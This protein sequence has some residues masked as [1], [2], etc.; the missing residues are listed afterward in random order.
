MKTYSIQ[1]DGYRNIKADSPQL[2]ADKFASRITKKKKLPMIERHGVCLFTTT[3]DDGKFAASFYVGSPTFGSEVFLMW[4][5]T[6][7]TFCK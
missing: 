4:D 7:W 1:Q 5:V 6:N 2:A 3:E